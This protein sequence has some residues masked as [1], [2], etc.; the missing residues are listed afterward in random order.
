MRYRGQSHELAVDLPNIRSAR[1]IADA[2]HGKHQ[3][4]FG[5]S[6]RSR[7]VEVVTAR[8]KAVAPG[9]R[10]DLARGQAGDEAAKPRTA[11]VEW[12]RRRRTKIIQRAAISGR[13]DGPAVILQEDTTTLVAPGWRADAHRSGALIL[14]RA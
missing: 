4:R 7:S 13:I 12:D 6:D 9:F 5:F 3:E 14:R 10:G 8:A 11:S 1:V 2:F